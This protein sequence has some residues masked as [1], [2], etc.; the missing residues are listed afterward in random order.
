M[1]SGETA[2]GQYPLEAVQYMDSI[3]ATAGKEVK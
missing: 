1:L 3:V 2:M